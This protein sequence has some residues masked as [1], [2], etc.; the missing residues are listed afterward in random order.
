MSTLNQIAENI[1]YKLGD[2]F[3]H[4][5]RESIKDTVI[6]YRADFIRQDSDRNFVSELHFGQIGIIEFIKVNLLEEF[7]GVPNCISSIC[8]DA[9]L[10][11]KYNILKSKNPIPL[12]IRTKTS[13][14]S[15]YIYL[16]TVDGS[17]NFTYT[18]LDKFKYIKNLKYSEHIIFYIILNNNV[19]IINNI[20][21]CDIN[22]SLNICKV[23]LRGIFENP[24]D[25]YNVCNNNDTFI[26]DMPF[27]LSRDMIKNISNSIVKGEYPI[28]GKD[29]EEIN[30]K[31]DI[32]E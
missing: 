5:L 3:N 28:K 32:N 22:E 1:A 4:T 23:M 24:R 12:A 11:N 29:G 25:L 19:Y 26:D 6:N 8:S 17:K 15:P 18:S 9:H 27:P 2:Q 31:Q 20:D 14:K 16:G 13:V 30:I 10:Q 21:Q 7:N